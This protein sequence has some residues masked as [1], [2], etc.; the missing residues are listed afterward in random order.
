MTERERYKERTDEKERPA[1]RP[2][3]REPHPGSNALA[4]F[5]DGSL[6]PESAAHL[7]VHLVDCQECEE[8]TLLREA[9]NER[10]EIA[11]PG[12]ETIATVEFRV[13]ALPS[14]RKE[15]GS[16][17]WWNER[18]KS[19]TGPWL[20]QGHYRLAL[21]RRSRTELVVCL[22]ERDRPLPEVLVV[23]EPAGK[24]G[25]P[26]LARG[27]TNERGEARLA[28][29]AMAPPIKGDYRLRVLVDR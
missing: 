24:P 27:V 12:L 14:R 21:G 4:R 28:F 1:G 10:I 19:A 8:E 26:E 18:G 15:G 5:V 25:T 23:L 2:E 22:R 13:P 16:G 20:T 7:R 6:D 17:D 9:L 29:R 3:A 11:D